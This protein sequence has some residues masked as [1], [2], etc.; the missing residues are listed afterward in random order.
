MFTFA[1]DAV[2]VS[3]LNSDEV[4]GGGFEHVVRS[5]PL[6]A[7]RKT[8]A[9]DFMKSAHSLGQELYFKLVKEYISR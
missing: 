2:M 8:K 5:S 9:V 4:C 1:D 7:R 6:P 3:L